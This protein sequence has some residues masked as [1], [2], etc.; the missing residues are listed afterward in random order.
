M[1]AN[2]HLLTRL[3]L[4][5]PL[6]RRLIVSLVLVSS[7]LALLITL[8][9]LYADYR[10]DTKA[11]RDELQL[12]EQSFKDSLKGSVWTLND[13]QINAQL[14]GILA[15]P[16]IESAYITVD[17]EIRWQQRTPQSSKNASR[18]THQFELVAH[19]KNHERHIGSVV[20]VANLNEVYRHLLDKAIFILLSNALKT[21]VVVG[22]V[23]LIFQITITQRL[24]ALADYAQTLH[25]F[26][27]AS[28]H[29]PPARPLT[30][31]QHDEIDQLGNTL[32]S[33]QE[34]LTLAHQ[35]QT[36]LNNQLRQESNQL[37]TANR[38]LS[39]WRERLESEVQQRTQALEITNHELESFTY[40]VSHDLRAPLR[41]ISGFSQA[42]L[43]DYG[44]K[45]DDEGRTFLHRVHNAAQRMGQLIEDLLKLSR[46]SQSSLHCR[47]VNLS[48]LAKDVLDQLQQNDPER[49][50]S[51]HIQ[52][53]L[54][55][56]CDPGLLRVVLDNLL[57]NAWKYSAQQP[58]AKIEFGCREEDHETIYFVRDNGAGFDMQYADKLF[59]PFQ[60]LHS[61]QE[62]SGEG[63]GLAT[64]ARVIHRH[65]GRI[66]AEASPGAGA[67]F[68]FSL[69]GEPPHTAPAEEA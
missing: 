33:M 57:G 10:H 25:L 1:T 63:I 61:E 9:Q 4:R 58:Q 49:T 14:K 51:V 22:V 12:I 37:L 2:P 24:K 13:A 20:I 17:N 69:P 19:Y 5:S 48:D 18:I 65:G 56:W 31:P 45:L 50:V 11:I 66:W 39:S 53:G 26:S 41:S 67:I 44:D 7:L 27:S 28:A 55:A 52:A 29:P 6:A 42:L 46:I 43:E 21:L 38:Q 60:R 47:H 35:Q 23:F 8:A 54:T 36:R 62:F 32:Q 34:R 68:S 3:G 16:H 64:V 15:M 59:T 30:D 40:A